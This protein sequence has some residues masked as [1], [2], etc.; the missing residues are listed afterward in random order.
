LLAIL[1]EADVPLVE[2]TQLSAAAVGD[3]AVTAAIGRA[4]QQLSGGQSLADALNDRCGMPPLLRWLMRWGEREATLGPAL[5]EAAAQYEQ[6][7]LFRA[8]LVARVVALAIVFFVGG[9]ITAAYALTVF[10]PLTSMWEGLAN[11][12]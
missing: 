8:E 12:R 2:A 5:R 11:S 3:S 6:R 9:G 10:V 4:G 1:I 7:A